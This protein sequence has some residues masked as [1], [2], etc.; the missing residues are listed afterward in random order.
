MRD[1][2]LRNV[3]LVMF[4]VQCLCV[5]RY[6]ADV[7]LGGD[8]EWWQP[9]TAGVTAAVLFVLYDKYRKKVKKG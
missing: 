7:A 2:G 1:R 6:V 8:T 9:V 4:V 3:C 5:L